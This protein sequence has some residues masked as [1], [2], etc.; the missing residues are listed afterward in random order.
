MSEPKEVAQAKI[1]KRQKERKRTNPKNEAGMLEKQIKGDFFGLS[2]MVC[3]R[4][5]SL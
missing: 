1:K 2:R 5:E 4:G 3:Q